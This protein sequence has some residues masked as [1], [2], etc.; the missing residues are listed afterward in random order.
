MVTLVFASGALA[1]AEPV[2]VGTPLSSGPPSVAV[3]GDGNALIAWANTQD[4]NGANNF[5]QYCI[6]PPGATACAHSGTLVPADSAQ[7]IDGVHVLEDGGTL[8]V[9]ADVFGTAGDNSQHYVPVQEWQST[10]GGATWSIV[11]G[12]L[13]VTSGIV[14]ADTGPV[15]AVTVPG[16]GVLGF[17]W[18]TASGPPT[19]NAFP[20]ASPAECSRASCPAGFATLEP[21]SN[22]DTLTNVPGQFASTAAGVL[23]VFRTQFTN[24]PLGC[25]NTF[26]TAYVYGSG[27][28][29]A[30]NDYNVSPG[31]SGSAWKVA[32]S[33]ADCDVDY[34]AVGG[35][36]SGFGI[37]EDDFGT[38]TTV[39]HR[40][41]Q[42]TAKFDTPLVTVVGKSEQQAALS[43]DG[44]GGIYGTYLLGGAGGPINLSY[45]AD[46]G[47]TW[48]SG[49]LNANKDAGGT[50]VTSAVDGVGQGW[51]AWTDNG[52]VFAQPFQAGDAI[53]P[54]SVGGDASSDGRTV[55]VTVSCT[56]VPCTITI[57]ITSNATTV[58]REAAAKRRTKTITLGTGKVTLRKAAA[59]KLTL[60]LTKA[61]KK[62]LRSK[63]G[64]VN[65]TA[66]VAEAIQ[67]HTL[68]TKRQ[69]RLKLKGRR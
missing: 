58:S 25:P 39:Y 6:L 13:S 32:L 23:G 48:T 68:V 38:G 5:V 17:A 59:K 44:A 54:P 62:F 53:S 65:V 8:V 41:N 64:H 31:S 19:F 35:G 4:L 40:F 11:N 10:D 16:A 67:H 46:G 26:G 2:N 57:T 61:G 60:H 69:L 22:P 33:Q 24:G 9:L 49:Q 28:Q 18:H 30:S 51:V 45:S 27:A 14:S 47:T 34:P 63:K 20:L 36:P 55:T 12:G 29:S 56:S 43:E 3:A 21:P 42:A 37:L 66:R 50:D 15:D 52:S 1:A 7:Y